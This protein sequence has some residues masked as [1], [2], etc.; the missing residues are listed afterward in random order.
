[1]TQPKILLEL[2]VLVVYV[3]GNF[4]VRYFSRKRSGSVTSHVPTQD[5]NSLDW[6]GVV[7][8]LQKFSGV[9]KR[10]IRPRCV[11]MEAVILIK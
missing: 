10:S 6:P 3:L 11:W 9:T 7:S 5:S 4:W 1:M 2:S 8:L